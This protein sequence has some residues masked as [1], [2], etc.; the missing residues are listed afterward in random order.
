MTTP[1]SYVFK[2]TISNAPCTATEDEVTVTTS[3]CAYY[4]RATGNVT[5]PIWS[6][7]P[8][9]TAGPATFTSSTSM[10][11]QDPDVVTNTT[12][13]QVDDLTI[14]AGAP[15]GQLVLT[16]GT[17]FTVNGD[18]MVVNGT[19]TAN[20][21][22]IMLLSPAVASTASFAS[23][24]S[25]W[26]LAVDAAVSCTVTGNIEIRGSLD[27]FDGI[28]DC[29]AN[30]VTLRSTAT[31]T[32]RLGP[33]DPGAS[34]VGNMRVQRRIPA[35]AT[36]WRLL[37]SPIA[38][39]I[40]DD[41]DDDFITAGY[42]GS[43]FP[44]FQ[45]PVGSGIS[46][47]SIRYY[48][49][50]EASAIDSVGM[51]GVANTT[52]SLAQGQGFAVWCGD[53]LGGTAAFIIDVQNGAPH[54]AN[55]PITLPMSYTNTGNALADGWNLVSNP[56]PS[57][58][59][60]ETMSLGAGVDSVVYFYNPA[61]G[62]S[63]T[64]DR[65]SNLGD[66]GG[67]NVIQSSQ[68][69]FL[70]ASGSAVTTTVSESDKINTNGG[71]IFG[72]GG[73]VPAHLRLSIASDVNTFSDETVVYFTAGTPELDER[74]ALKCGFAH[75]AA[76]QLATLASGAQIAHQCLRQYRRC[77]QYPPARER[78]CHRHLRHQWR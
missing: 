67:T 7:T 30:Q 55:S 32:G 21:N 74:D 73:Q 66:N 13:T 70:K 14:E 48:D 31:Y 60:F 29:S 44:G 23:T 4:S 53:A 8:T 25:F 45:S 69:F 1:G 49:E 51:H 68:G 39:R 11:V 63:A 62:N 36:N 46:W 56:L 76:P 33:V 59:D 16:T 22:S 75:S 58:I 65:Y 9:G 17:I 47:P 37:G 34:Y 35:G 18:A 42:P 10:V 12:N 28:F 27:L 41:W 38:G 57:P 19:L 5:D 52:V 24:T 2:W 6:D 71:G 72:I 40:V 61:N 50:T 3:V 20:D 43:D 78:G 64:Y 77:H 15:N 26:D 54:I